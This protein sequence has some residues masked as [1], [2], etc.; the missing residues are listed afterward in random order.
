MSAILGVFPG[1]GGAP[2]EAASLQRMLARMTRRGADQVA[3]WQ[4][5]GSDGHAGA[6]LAVARHDW[7]LGAGF[8][9]PVLVVQEGAL[10]VVAD[11]ALYYRDELRRK[12]A[13]TG[14]RPTGQTPSH[15]ILAAYRA[16]GERLPEHLEGDFAFILHDGQQRRVVAARDFG[17]R[18]PLHYATLADGTLVV[19]STIGGVLA[20]PTVAHDLDWEEIAVDAANLLFS[21]RDATC[22]RSVRRVV[23]GHTLVRTG[24]RSA[25][26]LRHWEPRAATPTPASFD[27]AA[28]QLQHLLTDAVAERLDRRG[29]TSI[30]LSGGWDSPSVYAAAQRL[31]AAGGVVP[32]GSLRSV[33]F[34]L[35]SD[36]PRCETGRITK[37]LEHWNGTTAW[38]DTNDV[39]AIRD[40]RRE[41]LEREEPW[42][43]PFEQLVRSVVARSSQ[44]G[45]HV[46]LDGFGGDTLFQNS[47][48][49]LAELI[50][51]GRW[52]QFATQWRALPV[53]DRNVVLQYIVRPLLPPPFVRVAGMLRGGRTPTAVNERT[54]PFWLAQGSC[55]AA[56]RARAAEGAPPFHGRTPGI[57]EMLWQLRSSRFQRVAAEQNGFALDGHME[58]RAP[59]WDARI[60]DFALSRPWS[61]RYYAGEGKILL[62][63]AMRDL[64]PAEILASRPSGPKSGSLGGYH[65]RW[66]PLLAEAYASPRRSSPLADAGVVDG[67]TLRRTTALFASDPL[68]Y[69]LPM[70]LIA[71][72]RTDMWLATHAGQ[73][74]VETPDAGPSRRSEIGVVAAAS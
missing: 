18:R 73:A 40:A 68:R 1:M 13:A 9:G 53:R 30:W 70:E 12:L 14:I 27:D 37:I 4:E 20:H 15:L 55:G 66:L 71:T 35:P 6:V 24:S 64:L 39:P 50:A 38:I 59:L 47:R 74:T 28:D 41:A 31:A 51:T 43:H 32:L 29:T 52:R 10:A 46:A 61:E 57:G 44:T 8:A 17:G 19:A 23:G 36:D 5:G 67:E 25:L 60:I 62:R 48:V 54:V 33:S 56:L 11:A 72:L 34:R 69:P 7:E 22:Y 2:V 16:W 21:V 58:A 26:S 3:L 42:A 65:Q 45:A 49:V 63:R